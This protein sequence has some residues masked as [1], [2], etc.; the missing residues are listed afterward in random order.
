LTRP[1]NG[2]RAGDVCTLFVTLLSPQST[3]SAPPFA[4]APLCDPHPPRRRRPCK[5]AACFSAKPRRLCD[6]AMTPRASSSLSVRRALARRRRCGS[7][8]APRRDK[9]C[10]TRLTSN[11]KLFFGAPAGS[12]G[13]WK[14]LRVCVRLRRRQGHNAKNV[15]ND[16]SALPQ[17]K[18]KASR[19]EASRRADSGSRLMYTN[20]NG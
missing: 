5:P 13:A 3:A 8:L 19:I 15:V 4:T 17:S 12:V 10:R 1:T 7:S 11:A 2:W 6:M 18:T 20:R 14:D 9:S 16:V